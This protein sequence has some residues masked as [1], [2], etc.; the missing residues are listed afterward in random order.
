MK[1]ADPTAKLGEDKACEFLKKLG[2]KIKEM[3]VTW[4]DKGDSKLSP[5][6]DSLKM[7]N[8]VLKIKYNDMKGE[9]NP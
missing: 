3:T 7:F 4:I 9:Y 5:M 8:E 6:K 1:I 2:Y